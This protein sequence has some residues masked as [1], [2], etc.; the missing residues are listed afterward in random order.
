MK[1][2]NLRKLFVTKSL[3][4][5]FLYVSPD[6]F[7]YSTSCSWYFFDTRIYFSVLLI[8]MAWKKCGKRNA[9]SLGSY[10][11]HSS[12][13]WRKNRKRNA[14]AAAVRLSTEDRRPRLEQDIT[15]RESF[16]YLKLAMEINMNIL[17]MAVSIPYFFGGKISRTSYWNFLF[18]SE[19]VAFV[20]LDS[21]K[22][23]S[24]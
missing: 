10:L 17:A 8:T 12:R 1:W 3:L 16:P 13:T 22:W 23:T 19:T 2:N 20:E 9:G 7:M 5:T 24:Q 18:E 11:L 4:N 15:G 14:G 21:W 6:S